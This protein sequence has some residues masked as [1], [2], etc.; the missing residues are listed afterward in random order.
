MDQKEYIKILII[1]LIIDIPM[2]SYINKKMY[3]SMFNKINNGQNMIINNNK[4]ISAIIAYLLLAY[5]LYY[6]IIKKNLTKNDAFILGIIIYGIYN[7]TNYFTINNYS[8]EVA[9]KDTLWGGILFYLI[10]YIYSKHI[11]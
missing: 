5:A 11:F 4:I 10:M 7:T 2:I 1:L 9:I 3:F 8:I 6:F